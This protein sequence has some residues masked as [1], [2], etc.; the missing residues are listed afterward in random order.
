VLEFVQDD[1]SAKSAIIW[2][3][4]AYPD[5]V[6]EAPYVLESFVDQWKQEPVEV[7]LELVSASVKMLLSRPAEGAPAAGKA[8]SHA[9]SDKSSV[10]LRDLATL[11]YKLLEKGPETAKSVIVGSNVPI[12]AFVEDESHAL[13]EKLFEELNSISVLY[14][15]PSSERPK[16][17]PRP[18]IQEDDMN[19]YEGEEDAEYGGEPS[20]VSSGGSRPLLLMETPSLDAKS[21]QKAWMELPVACQ[22]SGTLNNGLSVDEFVPQIKVNK[23]ELACIAAGIVKG[24]A[25]IY[26]YSQLSES[27]EH[28]LVELLIDQKTASVKATFKST[29]SE[30]VSEWARLV[31]A[32]YLGFEA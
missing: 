5:V 28:L 19:G 9:A 18:E 11:Y 20:S 16:F 26:A 24:T 14:A 27:K 31:C 25:K 17:V 22:K 23:M 7:R 3:F 1:V 10:E 32:N 29:N 2:S 6:E 4:G 12:A 15:K 30:F 8:L 13:H 21:F